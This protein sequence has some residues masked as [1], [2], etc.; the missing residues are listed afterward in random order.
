VKKR[1]AVRND[2]LVPVAGEQKAGEPQ[3]TGTVWQWVQT[4]YNNDTKTVPAKPENY[5]IRFLENGNIEVKA[6]CNQ[7]G[8]TYSVEGKKLSIKLTIS[9]MAACEPGSLEDAFVKDLTEAA[10]VFLKDGNLY[11]DL[12][13]DTGTMNF[14]G[15]SKD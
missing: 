12:K 14:S 6:D 2:R 4:L 5:T 13:Y 7:K 3:I 11:L 9:T 8:G 15:Q 10:I 1:F